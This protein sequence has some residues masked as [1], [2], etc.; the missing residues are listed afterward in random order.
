M[1]A[2]TIDSFSVLKASEQWKAARY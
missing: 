2:K 1:V